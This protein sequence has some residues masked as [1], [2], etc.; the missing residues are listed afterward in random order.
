MTKEEFD[1]ISIE[2]RHLLSRCVLTDDESKRI[3]YGVSIANKFYE[4]EKNF[5]N[6]DKAIDALATAAKTIQE[7]N[8]YILCLKLAIRM[9]ENKEEIENRAIVGL[10][11]IKAYKLKKEIKNE[12]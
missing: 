6:I 12:T 1:D 8:D 7:Q 11:A 4:I 9:E 2:I 5:E 3:N 10:N